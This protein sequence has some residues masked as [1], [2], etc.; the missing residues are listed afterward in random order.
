MISG[1]STQWIRFVAEPGETVNLVGGSNGIQNGV[2]IRPYWT[3][4]SFNEVSGFHISDIAQ[5]A[6]TTRTFRTSG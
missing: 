6:C 3:T 1:T 5:T 4:P 2:V